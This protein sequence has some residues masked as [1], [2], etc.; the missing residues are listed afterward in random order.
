MKVGPG[1]GHLWLGLWAFGVFVAVLSLSNA[2]AAAPKSGGD[3]KA[4]DESDGPPRIAIYV[5]GGAAK[6]FRLAIQEHVTGE[7]EI[8]DVNRF[9]LALRKTGRVPL[10]RSF[11]DAGALGPRMNKLAAELDLDAVI[12]VQSFTAKGGRGVRVLAFVRDTE[13]PAVNETLEL[14]KKK[15]AEAAEATAA[16]F[17]PVTQSLLEPPEPEPE[18]EPAPEAEKESEPESE[19][20][21]DEPPPEEPEEPEG[22][23]GPSTRASTPFEI[24][25]GARVMARR[26]TY[27]DRITPLRNYSVYT[28]IAFGAELE[29]FPFATQ[30]GFLRGLGLAAAYARSLPKKSEIEGTAGAEDLDTNYSALDAAL[31]YRFALGERAALAFLAGFSMEDFAFG[32][33]GV[34]ASEIPE[35]RYRVLRLGLDLRVPIAGV[36][37]L[38]GG[39]YRLTLS[40]GDVADRFPRS[41]V[42]GIDA[43]F[44]AA[45]P[46]GESGFELQALLLYHRYFYS[47]KSE[48]GDQ[49]IAGGAVDQFFTLELGAVYA[50]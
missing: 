14:G 28:V 2:S 36:D 49:Y 22:E 45:L 31:K 41:S 7:V 12:L 4:R 40:G 13:A 25:L 24:G 15:T 30:Q 50:F 18:P 27:T 42:G 48:P 8:V 26:F 16:A 44:G 11:A 17:S 47:M 38:A 3:A 43:L 23:S 34:F 5:E 32:G 9:V 21:T 20:K 10:G 37:F 35:V 46:L 39:S 29:A 33:E 1:L 19:E 6:P